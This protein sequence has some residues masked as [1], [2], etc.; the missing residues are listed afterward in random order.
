MNCLALGGDRRSGSEATADGG[1]DSG[2]TAELSS[3]GSAELGSEGTT[4]DGSEGTAEDGGK[5]TSESEFPE[6]EWLSWWRMCVLAE[7]TSIL[8]KYSGSSLSGYWIFGPLNSTIFLYISM[9]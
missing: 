9:L 8:V 3:E 1:S 4:E 7:V 2:A 6:V 5:G